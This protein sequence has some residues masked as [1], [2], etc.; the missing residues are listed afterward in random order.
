MDYKF[1]GQFDLQPARSGLLGQSVRN[2]ITSLGRDSLVNG[3]VNNEG[4]D[5]LYIGVGLGT[6]TPGSSDTALADEIYREVIS[7]RWNPTTG[8]VRLLCMLGPYYGNG[9]WK[10]I[11]IFDEAATRYLVS[12]C[13]GT[14]GW[15]SDGVLT[16]E[17]TIVM[18]GLASLRAQMSTGKVKAFSGPTTWDYGLLLGTIDIFQF[19]Y[20]TTMNTGALTVRL[21]KDSSNYYYWSWN[22]GTIDSWAHFSGQLGTA[23]QTGTPTPPWAS[24]A[25]YFYLGH[26][27]I[28]S[29]YYEYLDWLSF[30]HPAG[31]LM[32]RATLDFEKDWNEVINVYYTLQYTP[33]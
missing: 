26:S 8:Q 29:V 24:N 7:A 6:T 33:E 31:D 9:H 18:E 17:T 25:I 5:W 21:G 14:A 3:M 28:G 2:L 20:R 27:A 10:E 22:P 12:S 32:A 1:I 16:S 30:F 4:S 15:T 11:G 13:E 19:W 23:S